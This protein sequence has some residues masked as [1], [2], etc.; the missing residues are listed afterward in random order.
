ML[1][2]FMLFFSVTRPCASVT[3][4]SLWDRNNWPW[5][6]SGDN[7][8]WFDNPKAHWMHEQRCGQRAHLC[9]P[10]T[11]LGYNRSLDPFRSYI[12]CTNLCFWYDKISISELI[13]Y[14]FR[15]AFLAF[16]TINYALFLRNA[17]EESIVKTRT[18][19]IL[20]SSIA[21]FTPNWKFAQEAED[22]VD[23]EYA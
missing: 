1:Y 7:P 21:I 13:I 5:Y 23:N 3:V 12:V 9:K 20:R 8:D 11:L 17:L 2:A 19:S 16:L 15:E 14:G 22:K 4:L 10:R 18:A 6:Y